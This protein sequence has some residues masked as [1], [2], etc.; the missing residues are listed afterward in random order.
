MLWS[1]DSMW[2]NIFI[3]LFPSPESIGRGQGPSKAATGVTWWNLQEVLHT[4]QW[5][6]EWYQE[7]LSPLWSQPG[8]WLI[9]FDHPRDGLLQKVQI[10]PQ[11]EQHALVWPN[12]CIFYVN[13]FFWELSM[14]RFC[15]VTVVPASW[16]TQQQYARFVMCIGVTS[17][18]A[19]R[20]FAA[21]GCCLLCM[22]EINLLLINRRLHS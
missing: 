22:S 21:V 19:R 10:S 20:W 15:S 6:D 3:W 12:N 9:S 14:Q 18:A 13:I 7:P 4:R 5:R 17:C 11:G 1:S 2:E 8:R 16:P